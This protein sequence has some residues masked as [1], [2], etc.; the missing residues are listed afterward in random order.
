MATPWHYAKIEDERDETFARVRRVFRWTVAG[1]VAGAAVIIGVVAHEIPGRS[2]AAT[3]PSN[4]ASAPAT[5]P[6][7]GTGTGTGTGTGI[8]TGTGTGTGTGGAGAPQVTA[9]APTQ[10]APTVV[11]GGTG[12]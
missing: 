2:A 9:P 6:A 3:A 11:S 5:I 12:W 7:A 10:R 4:G 8:G 1:A